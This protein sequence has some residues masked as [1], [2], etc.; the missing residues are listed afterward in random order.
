MNYKYIIFSY[1]EGDFLFDEHEHLLVFESLGLAYQFLQKNFRKP[2]PV[3]TTKSFTT[4]YPDYYDA[5][6]KLLKVC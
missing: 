3:V 5:P 4:C 2:E 6:F 1:E